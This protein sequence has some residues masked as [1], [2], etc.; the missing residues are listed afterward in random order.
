MKYIA[1]IIFILACSPQTEQTSEKPEI[2]LG[3][4]LVLNMNSMPT[5]S[6]K[7]NLP[8]KSHVKMTIINYFDTTI[9]TL[10]D[11][12]MNAGHQSVQWDSKDNKANDAPSGLYLARLVTNR[13]I[14]VR[15]L[16]LVR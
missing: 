4:R 2:S 6:I 15:Q 5:T 9:K 3:P 13:A 12:E 14:Y 16:L 7:F 8:E 11:E 10:V 1:L